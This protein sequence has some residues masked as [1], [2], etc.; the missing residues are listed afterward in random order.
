MIDLKAEVAKFNKFDLENDQEGISEEERKPE[1]TD[2]SVIQSVSFYN[3]A[4]DQINGD[5]ED[6][7]KGNLKKAVQLRP[8][9]THAICLLAACM[10]SK[11]DRLGVVRLQS[12]IE[13]PAIKREVSPYIEYLFEEY[14]KIEYTKGKKE[15]PMPSLGPATEGGDPSV[16]VNREARNRKTIFD[17]E[18]ARRKE[19]R[20]QNSQIRQEASASG[21][22]A[23]DRTQRK[24]F[25]SEREYPERDDVFSRVERQGTE[26]QRDFSYTGSEDRQRRRPE[27]RNTVPERE[28]RKTD[29]FSGRQ[30]SQNIQK[31]FEDSPY[32]RSGAKKTTDGDK[33]TETDVSSQPRRK[34][35][36]EEIR[37][38]RIIALSII[39]AIVIFIVMLIVI[40][41]QGAKIRKLEKQVS[42]GMPKHSTVMVNESDSLK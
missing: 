37:R 11:G 6:M 4:I 26:R 32:K 38:N 29:Y 13:D 22:D 25:D 12:S 21:R 3:K 24:P 17:D 8:D 42:G 28:P 39:A 35:S 34:Y 36:K 23:Y 20:Q 41:D 7:A 2:E 1:I 15:K 9:F 5:L 40:I 19:L 16:Y 31:L 27:E 33:K 30:S 18:E 14:D 10:L